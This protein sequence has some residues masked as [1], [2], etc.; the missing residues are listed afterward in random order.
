L[1]GHL[2]RRHRH[3]KQHYIWM[4]MASFNDIDD[5]NDVT[6]NGGTDDHKINNNDSNGAAEA[7]AAAAEAEADHHH[8]KKPAAAHKKPA[9]GLNLFDYTEDELETDLTY[10][11]ILGVTEFCTGDEVK[12]AY[13]KTSLKYHPDK[14]GRESDDYVF[15]AVKQAYDTLYDSGKRQAYDST[16]LPFD[17]AIPPSREKLLENTDLLYQDQD[18]YELYGPVFRR[19][20]RYDARLRPENSSNGNGN[21]N[22]S[23]NKKK[24]KNGAGHKKPSPPPLLGDDTTAVEQVQKFYEYW[25]HFESWRDFSA[26][27]ADELRVDVDTAESRYLEKEIA[28]RAK[29]LKR[30]EM[31]R[32]QTLVERAM[33]CDPRLRR[34]RQ[35]LIEQKERVVLERQAAAE[36]AAADAIA[37]QVRLAAVAAQQKQAGLAQKELM[38]VERRRLRDSVSF[39]ETSSSSLYADAYA[40][41]QHIDQLCMTLDLETLTAFN[42]DM[43]TVTDNLQRLQK[44]LHQATGKGG[45]TNGAT[46]TDSDNK[47]TTANGTATAPD[48]KRQKV[49]WSKDELTALAKAA[50][51]FPAG[52]GSSRWDQITAT[53]N[54]LCGQDRSKQECIDRYNAIARGGTGGSGS[55]NNNATNAT[56]NGHSSNHTN[57]NGGKKGG[58]ATT[59]AAAIAAAAASFVDPNEWTVEQDQKL[60]EALAL[61]PANKLEKNERWNAIATHVGA[62]KTKKDCVQRFKAIRE[63]LLL[64]KS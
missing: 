21:N 12:K 10:Y 3:N 9:G 62:N 16:A 46:I 11:E 24:G 31:Q 17:D 59:E 50:R 57:A 36:Q 4:I 39:Q 20:L 30:N 19:N 8:H 40:L 23:S 33:E 25:I 2:F 53:V 60:Q 47:P 58:E 37:E 34:Y 29:V 1:I 63:A 13:R 45:G 48:Q 32:I 28:K 42:E 38:R 54:N 41:K 27:A 15:L 18:F 26:T 52:S 22:S 56:S 44:L 5:D 64:K 14:S 7:E 55:T 49:P 43:A 51:K 35:G 61:F 6:C